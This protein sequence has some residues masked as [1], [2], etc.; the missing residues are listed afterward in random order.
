MPDPEA[1]KRV[2]SIQSS[3]SHGYVGNRS[4]TFPLQLHEWEV[5]V[6]PTVHF[7]N[8][9]GYGNKRG[10]VCKASEV[11][12]LLA[13]LLEKN[14]FVYDAILTGFIPTGEIL[15][16]VSNLLIEYKGRHPNVKWIADPVMGDQGEAYVEKD[17]LNTYKRVLSHAFIITPNAFEVELLTGVSVVNKSTALYGLKRIYQ[18]YKVPQAVI[19]SFQDMNES[20]LL[21]CLGYCFKNNTF[22]S[23]LYSYPSLSG[24]FTGT[25]DLFSSLTL[26]KYMDE[27]SPQKR[28]SFKDVNEEES[29]LGFFTEV[30]GQVLTCMHSVLVRTK[31]Y[32]LQQLQRDPSIEKDQFL[33]S[34]VCELRL[35]QSR[36]DLV[37]S[38][39]IYAPEEWI[40]LDM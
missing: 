32:T 39:N 6:V 19:T 21:F 37:S 18:L 14:D 27:R 28:S 8:H 11:Y 5:D 23:F 9:L 38:K 20:N 31:E 16:V 30:I 22:H 24:T 1:S 3:V 29:S 36:D 7:S 12:E 33:L 13:T 26:A 25:G 4:A 2:L 35:I 17:V 40:G 34:N 10:R 15:Q